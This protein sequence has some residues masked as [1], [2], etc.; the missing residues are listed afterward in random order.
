MQEVEALFDG[1]GLP[2]FVSCEFVSNDNWFITFK[3]ETDAQQVK[4]SQTCDVVIPDRCSPAFDVSS[5]D[6]FTRIDDSVSVRPF[7]SWQA[8]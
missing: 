2:K 8:K 6:I 5:L 1:E 7:D 3:T 4:Y